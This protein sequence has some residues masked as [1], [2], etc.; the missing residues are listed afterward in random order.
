MPPKGS[1]RSAEYDRNGWTD[2]QSHWLDEALWENE[3]AIAVRKGRPLPPPP[4]KTIRKPSRA[5]RAAAA[6]AQPGEEAAQD[7]DWRIKQKRRASGW[8]R[9][10]GS[11]TGLAKGATAGPSPQQVQAFKFMLTATPGE[12]KGT[13]D[14]IACYARIENG[15]NGWKWPAL[16]P[17]VNLVGG[18]GNAQMHLYLKIYWEEIRPLCAERTLQVMR[19][20]DLIHSKVYGCH[21]ELDTIAKTV[22][23]F[24]NDIKTILQNN[25]FPADAGTEKCML[26]PLQM[27]PR[28]PYMVTADAHKYAVNQHVSKYW[29]D[30]EA[31]RMEEEKVVR[32]HAEE[33]G[34]WA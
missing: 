29:A 11:K 5:A 20:N 8:C 28:L 22:A 24:D 25:H 2:E 14:V 17:F 9:N 4:K 10:I 6:A 21:A 31:E 3:C 32:E 16:H 34:V 19:Y 27:K 33:E 7:W 15:V 12:V 26:P 23:R 18:E 13:S 30:W 1:G